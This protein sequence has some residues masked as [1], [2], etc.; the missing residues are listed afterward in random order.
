MKYDFQ[1]F[2]FTIG[3]NTSFISCALKVC[4]LSAEHDATTS[5]CGHMG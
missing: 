3:N 1:H 4:E 5:Y 2:F